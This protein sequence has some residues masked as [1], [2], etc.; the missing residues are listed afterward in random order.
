MKETGGWGRV[1]QMKETGGWGRLGQMK[2]TGDPGGEAAALGEHGAE[3]AG[4]GA[5]GGV[6]CGQEPAVRRD[7]QHR[8]LLHVARYQDAPANALF[9]VIYPPR[10]RDDS[11][12][13]GANIH[14]QPQVFARRFHLVFW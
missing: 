2:E 4:D 10:G 13:L 3:G 1:G 5:A 14:D 7:P 12:L 9:H 8:L 11:P 6:G